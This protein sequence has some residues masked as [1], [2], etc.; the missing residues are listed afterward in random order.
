VYMNDGETAFWPGGGG[1]KSWRVQDVLATLYAQR[2]LRQVLVVAIVPV[3]RDREYS[4]VEVAPDRGC[5]GADRYVRYLTE[6]VRPFVHASYRALRDRQ[7]TLIVGSSRGGLSAFYLATRRPDVFGHAIGM[8]SSFWAGLDPVFGGSY[9]GGSLLTAPLLSQVQA[10]L[11]DRALRPRLWIDWG[12]VRT[13]GHHNRVIEEAATRRGR[14][15]LQILT[16]TFGYAQGREVF[17]QEDP[18]GEHDERSWGR[19]LH[20][21]LPALW[22]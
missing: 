12:L 10:T 2:R 6:G 13:G 4:H 3:D 18:L 16:G 14:E 21:A 1:G 5:C 17:A 15:L 8:S 9:P 20:D 7:S 11:H 19:R 22:P